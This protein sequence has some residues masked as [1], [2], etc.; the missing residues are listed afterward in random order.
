[1][2]NG[3][4]GPFGL[5]AI[6]VMAATAKMVAGNCDSSDTATTLFTILFDP[7]LPVRVL[8]RPLMIDVVMNTWAEVHIVGQR[9]EMIFIASVGMIIV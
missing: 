3:T 1:M 9:T 6:A 2:I 8:N 5:D 4:R 7:S